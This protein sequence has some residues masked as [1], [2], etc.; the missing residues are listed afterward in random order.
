MRAEVLKD[1]L[2]KL[3]ECDAAAEAIAEFRLMIE[4][5]GIAHGVNLVGGA[6][7]IEF[8][9]QLLNAG[10]R[11]A[12]VRG[13]LMARYGIRE[14]QAYRDISEALQIVPKTS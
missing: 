14:S 13:R 6:S 12:E 3:D 2:A 1:L 8:A 5:V 7:R 10:A 9:R 4:A 11:R